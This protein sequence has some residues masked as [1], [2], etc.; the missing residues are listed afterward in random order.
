MSEPITAAAARALLPAVLE[1][2]DAA[3]GIALPYF[4]RGEQTTARVWSKAGGSPVTE[5]DVEVDAFLKVRLSE[6]VP[7]A[8]WLSE[9]T[10]DDPDRL[11]RD[12]V[13]IVDPIDGTRAFLSGNPDWSIAVALL[14]GGEP[15]LGIVA[16][17][18][19]GRVYA[20]AAG[21]GAYCDAARIHAFTRVELAGARV[22]GPKPMIERLARSAD[23]LE[24]IPRVPSLALRIVRVAEGLIDVGLV[25]TD[26]RDWDLA[27]AD[28][29]LR[30]A[31]GVLCDL[32]GEAARYNRPRPIHGELAAMPAT[33][34]GP[35][36]AALA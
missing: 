2:V 27:G 17:P 5:A 16:A 35:V 24:T 26:S 23:G 11:S 32:S 34:V 30:E 10:R 28:L 7:Q 31:G 3:S 33:L 14:S 21:G 19:L 18:A 20:A 25:S 8:G 13:W 12:T 4:R 15:V 6:L 1:V 29:I 22:T 36:L 9:E